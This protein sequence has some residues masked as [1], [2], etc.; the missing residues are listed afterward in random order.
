MIPPGEAVEG[1]AVDPLKYRGPRATPRRT[2]LLT[3]KVRYKEPDGEQSKLIAATAAACRRT[4]ANLGF[5]SAVAE[6]GMLLRDSEFKGAA[7]WS[8]AQALARRYRGEDADGYRAE[9]VRLVDLAAALK[10]PEAPQQTRR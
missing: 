10:T 6:F 2:E 5:A 7:T 9:F 3:V 1:A 4:T 8:S